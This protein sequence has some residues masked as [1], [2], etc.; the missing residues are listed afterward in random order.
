MRNT[1]GEGISS[2]FNKFPD[3]SSEV[4]SIW[5]VE[6]WKKQ[7]YPQGVDTSDLLW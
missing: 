3:A 1:E 2:L 6:F 4:N 5:C 7:K